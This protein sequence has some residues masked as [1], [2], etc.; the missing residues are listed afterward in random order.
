MKKSYEEGLAIHS[1]LSFALGIAR[2]TAKRKQGYRW[3]GYRAPKNCDQDA[4]A[5]NLAEGNMTGGANA[6]PWSVL[7]SRRPQ[8]RLETSCTRDLGDAC[9]E[10]RQQAGGRRR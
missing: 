9:W 3:A 2:C 5:L 6:S 10:R 1:A 8:T 4:D 7:R